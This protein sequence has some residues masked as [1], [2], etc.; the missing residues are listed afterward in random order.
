[1]QDIGWGDWVSNGEQAGTTG[2]N[3][4]IEA[5]DIKSNKRLRAYEHVRDIGWLPKSEGTEIHLGTEGKQ[6][7]IEAF[8]IEV[9]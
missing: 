9:V 5:I 4:Q 1:M 7:R 3:R 8:K 2:Q 6:L